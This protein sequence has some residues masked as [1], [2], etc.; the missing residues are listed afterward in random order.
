[1]KLA[2]GI[3][4]ARV[5]LCIKYNHHLASTLQNPGKPSTSKI[6]FPQQFHCVVKNYGTWELQTLWGFEW[7]ID[8]SVISG[9]LANV[10]VDRMWS[11]LNC[12]IWG[13]MISISVSQGFQA[14]IEI[15][16]KILAFSYAQAT[17]CCSTTREV[18]TTALYYCKYQSY[19]PFWCYGWRP[20]GFICI[21]IILVLVRLTG[22]SQTHL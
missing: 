13:I 3:I 7:T 22:C 17:Q 16:F 8:G 21:Y 15:S 2:K 5:K 6:C 14:S 19:L 18:I 11:S 1:M 10:I 12:G 9:I 20:K 4:L